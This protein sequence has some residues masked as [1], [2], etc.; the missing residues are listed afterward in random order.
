MNARS[1]STS[2][3]TAFLSLPDPVQALLRHRLGRYAPWEDGR[4]PTAPSCP[5]GMTTGAPDFVGV[6]VPKAGTTWWFSLVLAHP[7]VT[8]PEQ[9]EL[10]FFNRNFFE[11]ERHFGVTDAE[12]EAYHRFFP[13]PAGSKSGEWTPSYLFS[14]RLPPLLRRAAPNC[15]ILILLRDPVERY[16]SDI[17]RPMPRRRLRNVRYRGLARG[18]YSAELR[19]WEETFPPEDVLVLQYEACTAEPAAQLAATYRFLGLDDSFVPD[20]LRSAVNKTVT[21]RTVTEG[22]ER[23]LVEL[24]EPD[25]VALSARYPQIDLGRWPNFSYIETAPSSQT[26]IPKR[27]GS[28]YSA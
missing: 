27:S 12:L 25:V 1:L 28:E 18:F 4:P 14:Y 7:D 5:A 11:R 24:Y 10:L 16:K 15:K 8:G 17:S 22:F 2:A 9:K 6:G 26:V 3:R 23:F 19:P 13:R 20:E 21:K